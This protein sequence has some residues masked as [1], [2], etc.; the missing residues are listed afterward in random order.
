M[1]ELGRV[2]Q[3][4]D[5]VLVEGYTLEVVQMQGRRITQIAIAPPEAA[6]EEE[7]EL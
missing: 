1:A 7:V 5:V 4:G 3:V 6:E 2:A